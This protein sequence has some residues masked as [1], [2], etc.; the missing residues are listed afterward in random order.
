MKK[1][2]VLGFVAT[3]AA[4]VQAASITDPFTSF[5]VLGDSLSDNGNAAAMFEAV[6]G[7][8]APAGPLQ[9]P[10]V[11]SDG[12]TWVEDFND[13]FDEAGKANAN[14]SF[15]GA[16]ARDDGTS[17]PDLAAQIDAGTEFEATFNI[18]IPVTQTVDK[19]PDGQGGLM[20]REPQWGD[21][22]LVTVFIGGNDYLA[23]ANA[24]FAGDFSL[25]PTLV[26]DTLGVV[27]TQIDA[28]VNAGVNDFVV[29]TLPDFEQIPLFNGPG[30]GLGAQLG[31]SAALY[32]E[33][34]QSYLAGLSANVTVVD[35]FSALSDDDLLAPLNLIDTENAC[36]AAGVSDCSGYLYYDNIHP[37]K[38]GH[39]LIAKLTREGLR[40]TYE[41]QPV[42][43]PAPALMLI[44]AITG[45][46]LVR[47]RRP[48]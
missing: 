33:Q 21:T 2:S 47:R 43:L 1:L 17:V 35:V 25:L 14:L 24:A 11:S 42:P 4:P 5:W 26:Q 48:L 36:V 28:L 39:D 41:L 30:A 16:L 27:Q 18:G 7:F 44:T 15:G 23:A 31:G 22:P 12:F 8:P 9:Q 10:G 46:T 3:L 6:A 32:N 37:T 19:Y 34:L 45:L 29:M 20:A 13:A 38:K 40:E